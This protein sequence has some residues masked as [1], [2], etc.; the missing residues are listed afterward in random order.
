[1]NDGMEGLIDAVRN[2]IRREGHLF[3]DKHL[4]RLAKKIYGVDLTEDQIRRWR[5]QDKSN[6]IL[7]YPPYLR[8]VF[9]GKGYNHPGNGKTYNFQLI[10]E[11]CKEILQYFYEKRGKEVK[12]G[13][14]IFIK[15]AYLQIQSSR[16]AYVM[17]YLQANGIAERWSVCKRGCSV[18]KID[19]WKLKKELE[20]L[21]E[22]NG[23]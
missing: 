22:E 13:D 16:A 14:V 12:K 8:P 11:V 2:F 3:T 18:W 15:T 10:S 23:G 9:G 6:K 4:R 5:H 21:S 20:K 17:K 7:K 1:M 19:M